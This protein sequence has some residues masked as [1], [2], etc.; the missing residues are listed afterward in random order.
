MYPGTRE[1]ASQSWILLSHGNTYNPA[2][3]NT[4]YVPLTDPTEPFGF[5][6]S[7]LTDASGIKE[8]ESSFTANWGDPEECGCISEF[9]TFPLPISVDGGFC[10]PA[11]SIEGSPPTGYPWKAMSSFVHLHVHSE[12]SLLDGVARIPELVDRAREL[13]MP[14]VALTDHGNLFGAI[15]FYKAATEAGIKPIL[16]M[17]AYV[18]LT[19]RNDRKSKDYYHLT[20][21][22]E[23][24]EGYRNL[25]K[26]S[27][28]GYLT[29]F[30]YK[31]RVDWEVLEQH[32]QGLIV[33]TGCLKGPVAQ[34]LLHQGEEEARRMLQ[35][36]LDLFGPEQLYLELQDV[37][38]AENRT[39]NRFLLEEARRL[40]L[41]TVATNDVHYIA[42]DHAELQDVLIAINTGATLNDQ[43][44]FRLT[45]QDVYFRT[46][47]EMAH[48]FQGMEEALR[49]TLEIA[50]RAH[51]ELTL[52]PTR[53]HLPWFNIPE[54]FDSAEA[55]LEHLAREGL[56]R[57]VGDPPPPAYQE[58]LEQ[59]LGIIR[60]LGYAGYFL[61][62]WEIVKE[63]RDRGIPVGPGRGS[64]VGSL[65]LYTLGVTDLDPLRYRLFFE[66]FL[67]PE[68]VSPPDVDLDFADQ[69]RDEIIEYVRQRFG[70]RSVAQIITFG[71]VKARMAIKD[72]GRVLGLSYSEVDRISKMI[73]MDA[74]IEDAIRDNPELQKLA[75]DERYRMLFTYAQKIQGQVR[76]ASTHAAGVVITPGEITDH[77][78]LYRS[79]RGRDEEVI[80]TQYD[81]KSLEMVG[82][83]KVDLLGL[84]TLTIVDHTLRL[85]RER[86]N[87]SFSLED[88]PLDDP[89]TFA[90]FS[91]GETLGVFQV[92]SRGMRELLRQLKPSRFEDLIALNALYRPGPLS[93]GLHWDF[94]ERKHG[95]R[96]I[97]YLLPE[98]KEILEET[99]GV[100]VYQE[101]TMQIASRIAGFSLG[102]A[103]MLRRAM[104]KK[105][106]EVMARMKARFIDGAVE[107][108]VPREK[109]EELF[110]YI[111]PF[112][113]YGFNK[114]HAAAYALIAY[115]TAY[116]KTHFP[117][118]FMTATLSAEM[119]AQDFKDKG[120]LWIREARRMGL[121][122]LPPDI[123]QSEWNFRLI[124]DR[125]ILWGLG[126]VKNVGHTLV[127]EILEE[128]ATQP[129]SSFP[130]FVE[131][132]RTRNHWNRRAVEQLIRAGAFDSLHPSRSALLNELQ[133]LLKKRPVAVQGMPSLFGGMEP[134]TRV[135]RE[136]PLNQQPPDPPEQLLEM[137]RM[138]FG[139][140]VTA[141]PLDPYTDWIPFLPVHPV[142]AL[143]QLP[144]RASVQVVGAVA[145]IQKPR[146]NSGKR[147]LRFTLED[148]EGNRI[149]C[150]VFSDL[151]D[152]A[153]EHIQLDRTLVVRGELSREG[154]DPSTFTLILRQ[155]VP[156]P[157]FIE[158]APVVVQ[159]PDSPEDT[160][161]LTQLPGALQQHSGPH[162]LWVRYR[163]RWYRSRQYR[164]GKTPQILQ[165][166]QDQFPDLRWKLGR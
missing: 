166:L 74:S 142:D 25:M 5:P 56:K 64:A 85:I 2:K 95:R 117:A 107:R 19:H 15:E 48:L 135:P 94:V 33:L 109:A 78:P 17:E 24:T 160:S 62:I 130:D 151:L 42:P 88:I 136:D 119:G 110:E 159:I 82:L 89:E 155:L 57:R 16:G 3:H 21:L 76:Q 27:S 58:R 69:R 149:T 143:V 70:E 157:I 91:R 47:E 108:G 73:P 77:V 87:P 161:F 105:K 154:E 127:D 55:Y 66:R 52:D 20:L 128:R 165:T 9:G 11:P 86:Q 51:V 61:I 79:T 49:N 122:I 116:L 18:A 83:L 96:K 38:I 153:G 145:E 101:Q 81:M 126:A 34:K 112:A 144:D 67:N 114:S 139:F 31:P 8:Q 12:Y 125:E 54:T 90:L 41:K 98:L 68:R 156:L 140:P 43:D 158:R 100:I 44:R 1:F 14:A 50:E 133:E 36:L 23:T 92:E 134:Q 148:W 150:L 141:H 138:A 35:H 99:Y 162:P 163:N 152:R 111:V 72:V 113:G 4:V 60:Q 59:E 28:E 13:G 118:E 129:F 10:I 22:A 115:Q 103:D 84:R 71:R 137:E 75:Q 63:A 7:G 147:F 30:Y 80:S 65:V 124:G 29:G 97:E 132:M 32:K 120:Q 6:H 26:I 53:V 123:N 37:G 104:G 106:P 164:I 40:N 93:S 39:V 146:K 102:E 46:P 121:R 45:T 131:R